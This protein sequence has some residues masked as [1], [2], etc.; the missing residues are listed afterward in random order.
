V[1]MHAGKPPVWIVFTIRRVRG[2][3]RLTVSSRKFDVQ[4]L[5]NPYATSQGAPCTL[6][7]A[8]TLKRFGSTRATLLPVKFSTQS[9]P[10]P[11]TTPHGPAPTAIVFVALFVR[12]LT[13]ASVPEP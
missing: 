2:L 12:G 6:M 5:P 3:I 11:A 13:R 9:A 4:T 10:P 1:R 7:C 8:V